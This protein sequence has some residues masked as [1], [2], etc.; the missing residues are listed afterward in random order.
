[1]IKAMQSMI[2]LVVLL[3]MLNM[4]VQVEICAFKFVLMVSNNE[5]PTKF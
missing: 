1:M 3:H 4:G 5:K 2:S